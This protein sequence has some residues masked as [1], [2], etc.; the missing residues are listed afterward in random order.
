MLAGY[1]AETRIEACAIEQR[2]W[3]DERAA[4]PGS[5]DLRTVEAQDAEVA[6]GAQR[7][8][9]IGR[10]KA[11]RDV[12]DDVQAALGGQRRE[13]IQIG[14]MP[15]IVHGDHGPRAVRHG[16]GR[17]IRIEC[18]GFDIDVHEHRC[19]ARAGNGVDDTETGQR[20]CE[21]LVPGPDAQGR[22]RER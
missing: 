8:S 17:R 11:V 9:P 13:S 10:A 12:L 16:R 19:R 20:R 7:S 15:G 1:D 3:A 22:K 6:T 2:T 5:D 18:Q 4:L 14:R 21:H